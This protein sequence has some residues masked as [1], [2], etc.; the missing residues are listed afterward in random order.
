MKQTLFSHRAGVGPIAGSS[1]RPA[2]F[3]GRFYENVKPDKLITKLYF[4]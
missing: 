2:L 1:G 3:S 4:T